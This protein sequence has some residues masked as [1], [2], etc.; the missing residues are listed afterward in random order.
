MGLVRERLQHQC[1]SVHVEVHVCS[2]SISCQLAIGSVTFT[3]YT[4][5]TAFSVNS[6]RKAM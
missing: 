6:R 3:I 5:I 4:K 2:D 1:K